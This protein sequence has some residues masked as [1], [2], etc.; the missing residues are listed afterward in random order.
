M[1]GVLLGSQFVGEG[2][3]SIIKPSRYHLSVDT[4]ESLSLGNRRR[5][6]GRQ[7]AGFTVLHLAVVVCGVNDYL[8]RAQHPLWNDG[9][10]RLEWN[11]PI[12]LGKGDAEAGHAWAPLSRFCRVE[13]LLAGDRH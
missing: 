7:P 2:R 4:G 6:A 1:F 5:I 3:D 9:P 10:N 12:M 11:G 13:I 8:W